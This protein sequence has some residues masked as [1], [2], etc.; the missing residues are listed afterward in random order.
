MLLRVLE[1][2][3][4]FAPFYRIHK[5]Q[6]EENLNFVPFARMIDIQGLKHQYSSFHKSLSVFVEQKLNLRCSAEHD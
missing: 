2:L 4:S 1:G 5:D 6:Y 3:N